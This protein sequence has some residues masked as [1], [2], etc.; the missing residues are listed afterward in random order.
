VIGGAIGLAGLAVAGAARWGPGWALAG[1]AVADGALGAATVA[2]LAAVQ[3]LAPRGARGR[4]NSLFFAMVTLIGVG[5]GPL[6]TG[7]VSDSGASL[8][9]GLG[10]VAAAAL[11]LAIGGHLLA[12]AGLGYRQGS[13]WRPGEGAREGGT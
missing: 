3:T 11:V 10:L 13:A 8:A 2:S 4:G 6:L 12:G 1:L 9:T 5:L 7:L